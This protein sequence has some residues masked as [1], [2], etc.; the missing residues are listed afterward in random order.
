MKRQVWVML[1]S[2]GLIA[3]SNLFVLAGV[4]YNRSGEPHAVMV[5]SERELTAP[6]RY[7]SMR[8]DSG[9]SLR[10]KWRDN[11]MYMPLPIGFGADYVP[12]FNKDKLAELGFDVS[13]SPQD[14]LAERRYRKQLP[15][16]AYIVFEFNGPAYRAILKQSQGDL[17][18][19]QAVLDKDPGNRT[20]ISRVDFAKKALDDA[21]YRKSRLI[22][23]DAGLDENALRSRYP[24]HGRYLILPGTVGL[25]T[26][27]KELRGVITGVGGSSINVP[28]AYRQAV[29]PR[30]GEKQTHYT[31]QV[32]Y[33]KRFEPWI[34]D[35]RAEGDDGAGR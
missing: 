8:E 34:L 2:A 19:T 20:L 4:A 11:D 33:G 17:D 5:F 25:T 9:M 6:Y 10:L 12:W 7:G 35:A 15:H 30:T 21:K 31:V 23:V 29:V 27:N 14:K 18:K 32:A 13:E 28:L 22:A 26:L 1:A 16:S 24:D 3:L